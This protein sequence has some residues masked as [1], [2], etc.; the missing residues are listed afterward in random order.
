MIGMSQIQYRV[1]QQ[2]HQFF[3]FSGEGSGERLI[4]RPD[5]HAI[6]HPLPKL[7]LRGPELSAVLANYQRRFF[8]LFLF[9][10]GLLTA[11][12]RAHT[13]LPLRGLNSFSKPSR[14]NGVEEATH[15]TPRGSLICKAASGF[16][17]VAQAFACV[18]SVLKNHHRLKPSAT[19]HQ[20][21]RYQFGPASH[22][23]LYEDVPQVKLHCLLTNTQ[24]AADLSIRKSFNAAKRHLRFTPA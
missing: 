3:V 1:T 17:K 2:D 4:A 12:V 21:S 9:V 16:Q 10:L 8:L 6:P 7:R 23:K 15:S 13:P 24:A 14:E 22:P 18:N 11:H 19:S 5:H 20:Q